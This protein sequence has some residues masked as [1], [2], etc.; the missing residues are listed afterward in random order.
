[1]LSIYTSLSLHFLAIPVEFL[2][3]NLAGSDLGIGLKRKGVD[4]EMD[5]EKMA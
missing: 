1:M 2:D 4:E 3:L 5:G